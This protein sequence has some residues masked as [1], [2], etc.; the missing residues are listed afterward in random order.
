M[1]GHIVG[2]LVRRGMQ[3]AH[4]HFTKE[5]Y[6][7][8]LEQDAKLYDDAGPEMELKPQEFLPVVITGLVALVMIWSV[9]YVLGQVVSS[10]TMIESPSRT[11]VIDAKPPPYTSN[12]KEPLMAAEPDADVEV[13]IIEQKP[14]TAKITT[15][16]HHLQRIGGFSARWRGLG[17]AALYH[18]MHAIM[19]NLIAGLLGVG[20]IGEAFASIFVSMGLARLHMAWTHKMIAYP[21][22]QSWVRRLPARRDC[23]ALLLPAVVYAAAQQATIVLP[24]LVAVALGVAEPQ[25]GNIKHAMNHEDCSKMV[26]LG[27]RFFA[28]PA[29]YVLVGLAVLLP[30]SVTLTRIEA[31]L[32]PEGEETIVN[33]DKAAVM[34]DID[35]TARGGCRALFV[36]A[37]RSFDRSSRL[38]LIKLYAKMIVAQITIGLV[39]VHLMVAELYVIGG[40]RLAIFMKSASAQLKLMAIEAH[41]NGN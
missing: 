26:F 22:T 23:K 39:A 34:G 25:H 8:K 30:A 20:L 5:Q 29:T 13:T 28:V 35:L 32:L 11:A 18:F 9:D 41:K 17:L 15:T 4:Q 24:V 21:S 36:Q 33:F 2:H 3:H 27:L 38:R 37:W 7:N 40:E 16:I 12:E 6:V 19:T 10:L 14:I 1:T 31:L